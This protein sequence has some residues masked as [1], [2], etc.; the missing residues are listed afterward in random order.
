M[1]DESGLQMHPS[2]VQIKLPFITVY[3]DQYQGNVCL[4]K[5]LIE[6]SQNG[7]ILADEM[8]LGKTIEVLGIILADFDSLNENNEENVEKKV[9]VHRQR[10]RPAYTIAVMREDGREA[11]VDEQAT[12]LRERMKIIYEKT[13]TSVWDQREKQQYDVACICG[14]FEERNLKTCVDCNKK[15][16]YNCVGYDKTCGPFR[17][18]QCWSKHPPIVSK[19]TLI[20]CPMS[21]C[22]QWL[23]EIAK[24]V[25]RNLNVLCYDGSNILTPVYPTKLASY[26]VVVTTYTVLQNEFYFVDQCAGKSLRNQRKYSSPGSAITFVQWKRLCLDEAQTVENAGSMVA[27]MAQKLRADF[28]WA[29]TGTPVSISIADL[30][31]LVEYLHLAPYDDYEIFTNTLYNTY[32]NGDETFL[33]DFFAKVLWRTRKCLVLDQIDIPPQTVRYHHVDFTQVERYF[34]DC[35]T[36][37]C[38]K[39]FLEKAAKLD[40]FMQLMSMSAGELKGLLQP[41]SALRRVCVHHNV[42]NGRYLLTKKPVNSMQELLD[43]LIARNVNDCEDHLRMIIASYNGLAGLY[44]LLNNPLTA[45]EFYVKVMQL[46][47]KYKDLSIDKLPMIHTI[48]NLKLLVEADENLSV[49]LSNS[50]GQD[51]K[52]SGVELKAKQEYVEHEY[53]QKYE[54][55]TKQVIQVLNEVSENIGD[56]QEKMTNDDAWYADLVAG[57]FAADLKNM[58]MQRVKRLLENL[59]NTK[60]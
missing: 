10:K 13:L 24:H 42:V 11:S 18:S 56:L 30:Y 32:L 55:Q 15:Q 31:G 38:R 5:P 21:L 4:E 41:V 50:L 20:V 54:H 2:Y 52:L 8:G 36:K 58:L 28:R 33:V 60:L 27:N 44:L 57:I 25:G 53:I 9:C 6:A 16:H 26:D 40:E 17:C 22:Q 48:Y 3:F 19:G 39:L 1:T 7:A 29:I 23:N 43:A 59:K 34:Y 51:V 46:E 35:E 12:T 14:S 47:E 37:E 45:A 49:N